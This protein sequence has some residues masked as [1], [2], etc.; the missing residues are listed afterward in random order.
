MKTIN[1]RTER[2]QMETKKRH[3]GLAIINFM[4]FFFAFIIHYTDSISISIKNA[5]P[6]I[7]LPLLT[8]FAM[9]SSPAASA[10]VG[11]ITGICMDG[12]ASG[13]PGEIIAADAKRGLVV[14]C[15]D[16]D[17]IL[18]QIQMP[19]AKRM[20]AKDYLRGHTMETGVCLGKA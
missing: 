9:F 7:I 11:L 14:S 2:K 16:H 15:G 6:I 12:A 20:N 13:A 17:V 19:G 5:V 8:A 1:K 3:P 18:E 4:L 10:A